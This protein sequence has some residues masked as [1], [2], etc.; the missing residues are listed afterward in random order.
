MAD[1]PRLAMLC[2][3]DSLS[4]VKTGCSELVVF[5]LL[6]AM[7]LSAM[8]HSNDVEFPAGLHWCDSVLDYNNCSWSE[9]SGLT[10]PHQNSGGK[11]YSVQVSA[12]DTKT[13]REAE[14]HISS[15]CKENMWGLFPNP[16]KAGHP[17]SWRDKVSP[18]R[19]PAASS[20]L[21]EV[22]LPTP[23]QCWKFTGNPCLTQKPDP[24]K[25][26]TTEKKGWQ[27]FFSYLWQ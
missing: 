4:N 23:F 2:L 3:A 24:S 8:L 1:Y 13:Q 7:F 18:G 14:Q 25:V 10:C 12:K 21:R 17:A 26:I 15:A 9:I 5:S 22:H 11:C 27:Q 16:R 6:R 20:L 19:S